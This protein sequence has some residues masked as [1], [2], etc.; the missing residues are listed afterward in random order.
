MESMHMRHR[1]Y[2]IILFAPVNNLRVKQKFSLASR[3][4]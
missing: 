3:I 2:P 1:C 4:K